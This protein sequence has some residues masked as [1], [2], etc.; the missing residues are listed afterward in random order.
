MRYCPSPH[1]SLINGWTQLHFGT[2]VPLDQEKSWLFLEFRKVRNLVL[3]CPV[4]FQT[5]SNLFPYYIILGDK[6][7][8]PGLFA[9]WSVLWGWEVMSVEKGNQGEERTESILNTCF[10]KTKKKANAK[11]N[12]STRI[13]VL[14]KKRKHTSHTFVLFKKTYITNT[15]EQYLYPDQLFPIRIFSWKICVKVYENKI[16]GLCISTHIHN[17]FSQSLAILFEVSGCRVIGF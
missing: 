14:F 13:F 3:K 12:T 7:Y 9:D 8:Q 2:A 6:I 16:K 1:H 10:L 4:G 11:I 17:T 5:F 15:V